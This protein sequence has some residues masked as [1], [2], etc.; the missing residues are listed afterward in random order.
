ML[1]KF[2]IN[3]VVNWYECEN[4]LF[5]IIIKIVF[6]LGKCIVGLMFYILEVS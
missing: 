4:I 5:K 6:F 2:F 1:K 3:N